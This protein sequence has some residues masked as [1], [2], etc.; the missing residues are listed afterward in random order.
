MMVGSNYDFCIVCRKNTEYTLAKKNIVKTINGNVYTFKITV[1][2]C[3]QCGTEMSIPGL[4]DRNIKEVDAQYRASTGIISIENIEKLMKIYKLG[5]DPLSVALGFGEIT[6]RRYLEGQMPSKEYSD[7]MKLALSSPKF[8]KSSLLKN[9]SKLSPVAFNKAIKI[10]TQLDNLFSVSKEMLCTISYLF[11]K[12]HEFTDLELQ[13]LL[14][15]VQGVSYAVNDKTIFEESC[16][17]WIHGPVYCD[18][19]TMFED[20]K[21]NLS[22]DARF[23]IVVIQ[24]NILSKKD[25]KVIDLVI[26]TFG[27]YSGRILELITRKETPWLNARAG[28]DDDVPSNEI[29]SANVIRDYFKKEHAIYNFSTK[30]GIMKYID[31]TLC[32]T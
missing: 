30:N 19:H 17:A 13:K 21:F 24:K 20:F 5:K 26:E 2:I 23:A 7:I 31:N 15:Y 10:A 3:T 14:Y 32:H 25:C 22:D 11:S 12:M 4:I 28:C 18:V 8:M 16:Q 1:A 6:I 29:I 27:M 9:K